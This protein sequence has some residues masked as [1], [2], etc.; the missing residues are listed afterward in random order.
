MEF[1]RIHYNYSMKNNSIPSEK[2]YK[3]TLMNKVELLIKR[4]RWK[5]HLTDS[6]YVGHANLLFHIFKSRKCPLQHKGL[7]DFEN[8]LLELVKNGIEQ[9]LWSTEQRSKIRIL[10]NITK[11][12]GLTFWGKHFN[13]S[14]TFVRVDRF[15]IRKDSMHHV[16]WKKQYKYTMNAI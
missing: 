15:R 4:M 8:G 1:K 10:K 9:L 14:F 13:D 6:N 16:I 5:A 11:E 3:T 7:I 12:V 2:L